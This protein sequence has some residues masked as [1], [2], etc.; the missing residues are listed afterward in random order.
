M[1]HVADE[2][3]P[4][5]RHRDQ[6]A[7][8]ALGRRGD[9]GRRIARGEDRF[10]LHSRRNESGSDALEVLAV[11]AHLLRLAQVELLDVA[12]RPAVGDVNEQHGGTAQARQPLHVLDDVQRRSRV[13]EADQDALVHQA[14]H[15]P[16]VCTSSHTFSAA[17]T[18]PTVYA[19]TFSHRGLTNGPILRGRT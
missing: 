11:L 7:V 6:V 15:P 13:L 5:R 2:L 16:T 17:I 8:L 14:N 3:V 4:V 18:P 19:S 1:D 12:R 9:L 10:G